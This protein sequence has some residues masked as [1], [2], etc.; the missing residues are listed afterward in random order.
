MMS[1][2]LELAGFAMLL[3]A[4]YLVHPASIV[5]IVGIVLIAIGYTRKDNK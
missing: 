5:G 2:V 4:A 3:L 1:N